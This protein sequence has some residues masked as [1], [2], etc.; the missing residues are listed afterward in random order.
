M[1]NN[2]E[3]KSTKRLSLPTKLSPSLVQEPAKTEVKR[4][5]SAFTATSYIDN[6]YSVPMQCSPYLFRKLSMCQLKVR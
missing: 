2:G 3:F 5:S 6:P 4:K 1:A